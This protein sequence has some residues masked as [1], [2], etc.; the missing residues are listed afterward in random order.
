VQV[1]KLMGKTTPE[2]RARYIDSLAVELM[3]INQDD[4][5]LD[6]VA[7]AQ[8][9]NDIIVLLQEVAD[10]VDD[11]QGIKPLVVKTLN[12]V[13]RIGALKRTFAKLLATG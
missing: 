2:A 11:Y 5:E 4:T 10:R 6:K 8:T 7:L 13:G 1:L 12:P 3:K 9:V